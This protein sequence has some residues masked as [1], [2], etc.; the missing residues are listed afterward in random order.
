ML[1]AVVFDLYETLVTELDMPVRRASS[2]ATELAVDE[3]A[4]KRAWKSRRPE[5]VLGR[6]TF[7][8]A[9]A[10]IA[11]E[12]GG[13]ADE[14]LLER[15]RSERIAQKAAVLKSVE[16]DVLAAVGALRDRGLELAVVTNALAEDVA[17][18][19]SSPLRPFF[20]VTIFS[21][22]VGLAKPDPEI[23][24]QACRALGVLPRCAL[25]VGDGIEE[26]AGAR[27]AGLAVSRALWFAAR[28]PQT[29]VKRDDLGLWRVS[30][31]VGAPQEH[32]LPEAS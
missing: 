5:I 14:P 19:E 1:H 26:V 7:H 24:L 13:V 12:L 27:A 23:Y 6:C 30:Q 16:P 25:F 28:W 32:I 11:A 17:G 29:T 31:V 20:D 3:S 10:Q 9:L 8:D 15:L 4:Y 18:W 21:Y 22:A 2:L